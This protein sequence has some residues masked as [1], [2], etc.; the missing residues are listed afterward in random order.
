MAN[1]LQ[2]Y[3]RY[4]AVSLRSQMQYRASFIMLSLGQFMATGIEF[5]GTLALFD[6][7]GH[8]QGWRL[9]EVALFYGLISISFA[10]PTPPHAALTY[11]LLWSKAA[12]LTAC[13]CARAIPP[14]N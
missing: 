12:I 6:R 2:L 11:F 13:C 4:I 5:I 1:S 3:G 8:L 9:E 10:L 7:F 14:Y